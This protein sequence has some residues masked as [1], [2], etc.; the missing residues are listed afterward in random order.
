LDYKIETSNNKMGKTI[1]V[2]DDN[3]LLI[4]ILEFRLRRDGYDVKGFVN[5]KDAISY[6][7]TNPF[8]LLITDV[9][10]PL[11]NGIEVIKLVREEI[12][13]KV[14][15]LVTSTVHDGELVAEVFNFGASDFIMKP[16]H[17]GELSVRVRLL[18]GD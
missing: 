15:I 18:L 14:P 2:T 17:A 12:S 9:Y 11:M 1:I 6:M 3:D 10:M 5:G 8:D 13:N 16:F 4:G 7:R